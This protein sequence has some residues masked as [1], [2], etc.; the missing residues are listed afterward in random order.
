MISFHCLTD[1][2]D[3]FIYSSTDFAIKLFRQLKRQKR[4]SFSAPLYSHHPI[5]HVR[6]LLLFAISLQHFKAFFATVFEFC[7][8]WIMDGNVFHLAKFV[9]FLCL[10]CLL[11]LVLSRDKRNGTKWQAKWK[12]KAAV[13]SFLLLNMLGLFAVLLLY[14][15]S[16][17]KCS[18]WCYC[19]SSVHI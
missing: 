15:C 19:S 7:R 5:I 18:A 6:R 3:R 11:L 8:P 12:L 10:P 4:M 17:F 16:Y 9:C 13:C 14:C 2:Y 1:F